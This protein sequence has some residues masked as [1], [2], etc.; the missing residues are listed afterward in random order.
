VATEANFWTSRQDFVAHLRYGKGYSPGTC[1]AYHSDLG[2]WGR[3][4]E[5]ARKDWRAAGH[6]DVEQFNAWQARERSVK[7]HIVSR[8]VSCLASFYKWAVKNR[9]VERD[10][11]YLADKPRR[12]LRIPVWLD[13]G[14]QAALQAA[15]RRVDDLPDNIFGRKRETVKAI[16]RRYEM[17]FGLLLASGLRISEA[18]GLRVRDVRLKDGV[19]RSL[20]VIGKGNKERLVPLPEAFGQVFGFWLAD[21]PRDDFVFAQRPG[22]PPPGAPAVRAYLRRLIARTGIDKKVTPHKLRHTYATRL[23]EAGAQLVDIQALLGHADIG[24]TQV[25]THVGEDRMAE[26]VSKL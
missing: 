22:G 11:I 3:W 13:R 5:E 19:A 23:L 6:I 4:L 17:L 1:Y 24:S 25:Y 16:R 7:P 18:L 20:R 8:R 10:P 21:R 15:T 2:I 9:L 26:L 14:E 12:P